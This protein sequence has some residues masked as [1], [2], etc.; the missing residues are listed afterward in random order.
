[1]FSNTGEALAVQLAVSLALSLNIKKF[2]LEGDF[3]VVIESLQNPSKPLDWRI[4][5]IILEL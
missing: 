1:L 3:Q 2:I 4:S 5:P